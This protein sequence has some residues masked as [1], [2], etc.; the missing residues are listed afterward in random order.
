MGELHLE[1]VLNRL[2]REFHTHLRSGRPQ[3]V[4]R[5]TIAG[6]ATETG[7]FDR[8][9]GERHHFAQ[10]T[11]SVR[12]RSRGQGNLFISGLPDEH[13]AQSYVPVIRQ[14]VEEALD[15]GPIYG[16]PA[17]DLAVTLDDAVLKESQ[18]SEMA[19]RIATMAGV[20]ATLQQAQP[21]LLEPIMTAEIITPEE[22]TGE[23]LGDLHARKGKTEQLLA[24]GPVKI[25][26]AHAPLA[27]MFGYATTLRSLTQGRG[28]FTLQFDHYG[29]VER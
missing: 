11:F 19:F 9:L 27:E 21:L 28:T 23:V 10:V 3:V 18:A 24:K 7:V 22:F 1:V 25:I 13:P 12:P 5:E 16:H 8:E 6:T 26:I 2:V 14:A 15:G 17:V 4:Y 20:K 29:R